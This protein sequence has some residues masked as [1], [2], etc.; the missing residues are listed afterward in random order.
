MSSE[1]HSCGHVTAWQPIGIAIPHVTEARGGKVPF[2]D[3]LNN[4]LEICIESL[5]REY[6]D[7]HVR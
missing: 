7:L 5:P 3:L 2:H 6:C 1:P 4:D